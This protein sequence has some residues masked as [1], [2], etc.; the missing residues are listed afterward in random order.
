MA[1]AVKT[2]SWGNS[3]GVVIPNEIVKNLKINPDEEIMI[4]VLKRDNS[5]KEIFGSLK[6]KR[7][8][9]EILKEVRKEMGGAWPK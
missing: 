9:G 2:K 1:I 5:L 4:E 6:F 3:I 7:S 8:S